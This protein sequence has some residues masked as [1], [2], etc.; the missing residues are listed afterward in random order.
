MDFI[1]CSDARRVGELQNTLGDA[2]GSERVATTADPTVGALVCSSSPY[3]GLAL[4][5]G[6]RSPFV[7]LGDP[8]L[9]DAS[10]PTGDPDRRTKAVREKFDAVLGT[11]GTD[12]IDED[13]LRK[14]RTTLSP[15]HPGAIFHADETG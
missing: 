15:N 7:V 12:R 10:A 11:G 13:V 8:L 1:F 5:L 6:D 3:P 2:C 4:I 14:I 9:D